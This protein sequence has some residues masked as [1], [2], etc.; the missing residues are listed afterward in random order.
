MLTEKT[1]VLAKIESSYGTD[2]APTSTENFVAVHNISANP[3]TT[4]NDTQA[5]DCSLSAREGT[6]GRQYWDIT[7]DHEIQTDAS[8]PTVLP[9]DALLKACGY[10]YSTGVYTPY[11]SYPS[12][13]S[14]VTLWIYE[15]GLLYK[16]TG[17]RGNAVF[18][19]TAGEPA[20]ISFTFQGMYGG[21]YT[22][23][24]F[25]TTCTDAGGKP[26]VAINQSLTW[27]SD[28]P[29]A[30]SLSFSL[31]N[32]LYARPTLDDAGAYGIGGI[33]ITNR[34]G[35]GSLDPAAATLA[36]IPFG[37]Q[38]QAGTAMALGYVLADAAVTVTI[39]LP[40][41][42]IMNLT[43]GDRSGVR[44]F[45]VPFRIARSSGNDEISITCAAVT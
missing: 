20:I 35:E 25:P 10:A 33:D 43:P 21:A 39:A 45:D 16:A 3:N 34:L 13:L 9:C 4:F 22:D 31:G 15:D 26:L 19:L 5:Q 6:V 30:E 37:T 14:S 36:D 1:V 11:T 12:G 28:N 32:T 18:N 40:K 27:G 38:F 42:Q 8:A 17:V 44:M 24:A 23:V 2:A 7:F 29:E 41:V